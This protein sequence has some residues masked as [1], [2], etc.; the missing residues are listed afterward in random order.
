MLIRVPNAGAIGLNKDLS[1]HELPTG[2]WT[3]A[4]NIRFLD[5]YAYQFYGHGEVYNGPAVVPQH[6]LPVVVGT[7]RYWLYASLTKIYAVTISGGAAVHTNLTR[8][9]AS[10]DVD[11]AA[12]ANSWT[13][14]LLGG[15]PVMNPGNT[16][17]PPQMWNLNIANR[18][19]ALT[20]WPASTYCKA[21]RGYKNFLV[22]LNVTKSGTNYPFMVKW[23]HPADPGG[24]PISWDPA[25]TTKD[26]GEADLA[27]GY[28]PIVDGLQL[29]DSFIIY[30]EAS[31]WRMDYVGGP[32]VFRFQKVLGTSGA[33]NRNCIVEVDGYHV[34]LTGSDVIAHDGVN[35]SSILDKQTRRWLFQNIDVDG[36]GLCFVF[37]NPFFNEVFICFPAIGATVPNMAI[38]WNYKDKTVS[39]RQ[40]PNVNHAAFGPVDNGLTGNWNQDSAPWA[41]D[42]TLWNGPDFVPSTARCLMGSNDQ[43]LFM[44]DASSSFDGVLPSA[45]LE[46]RGLSLGKPESIKLVRGIRARITGNP[47][48]TVLV[49]V[50]SQDDPWNE[51]V[52]GPTVTHTIGSTVADDLLVSGR[53]LTVRFESGSAYQWRLDSYDLDVMEAGDW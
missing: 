13:S 20:N 15:I 18:M 32:F 28:D 26:A 21:L 6:L 51:P 25:D 41:S 8:Q 12:T 49:R 9:T 34:V 14:T 17:D 10:V 40:I 42:L 3:D 19:T 1:Q 36:A 39:I 23:S 30:K 47:G 33:L 38:I 22:A 27:E 29:R 5:G 52:W 46:R 37:K 7:Q 4:Q 16:V 24:V 35:A 44:M 31:V 53:Y 48:E 2:A 11:Y 45:Y 50:G 43:K